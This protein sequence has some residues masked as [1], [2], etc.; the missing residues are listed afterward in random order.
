VREQR[1]A[2]YDAAFFEGNRRFADHSARTVVSLVH[3]ALPIR[4]VVDFG[5]A[6]GVWLRAWR[7]QGVQDQDLLGLDGDYVDRSRL[8]IPEDRFHPVD[9]SQPIELHRRFDL[10]QSLEV[11]EHLPAAAA[12]TFVATLTRHSSLVLFSAAP[13]GQGGSHHVNERPYGYW[14]DLFA[15]R[16]FCL[17][18]WVRPQIGADRSLAPWYRFNTFLYAERSTLDRLPPGVSSARQPDGASVADISPALYKLRKALVRQLP[19]AAQDALSRL[20]RKAAGLR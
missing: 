19:P 1:Q 18:D 20:K 14:R 15:A 2:A 6:E 16:G 9:L 13:P 5:C 11:A 3:G 10:V 7:N 17:L 12:A 4:S 8:L